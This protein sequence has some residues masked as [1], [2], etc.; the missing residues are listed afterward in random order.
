MAEGDWPEWVK[1]EEMVIQGNYMGGNSEFST[2]RKRVLKA[3]IDDLSQQVA[4]APIMW[5]FLIGFAAI[6][7]MFRSQILQVFNRLTQVPTWLAAFQ[8]RPS[9]QEKLRTLHEDLQAAL[10]AQH[11]VLMQSIAPGALASITKVTSAELPEE[12]RR[13]MEK[14]RLVD[15]IREEVDA[16]PSKEA[17]AAFEGG[18][19]VSPERPTKAL[20]EGIDAAVIIDDPAKMETGGLEALNLL[21]IGCIMC[22]GSEELFLQEVRHAHQ[23]LNFLLSFLKMQPQAAGKVAEVINQLMASPSWSAVLEAS[24]PLKETLRDLPDDAQIALGLQHRKVLELVGPEARKRAA[25]GD[26]PECV[27]GVADRMA[28]IRGAPREEVQPPLPPPPSKDEW[29][30]ARTPEGHTYYY[31]LRTRESTWDRPTALGGARVYKVGDEVEVWSNGQRVWGRGR[32]EKAE[33][34]NIVAEF[35]LPSGIAAKKELPANHKDLRPVRSGSMLKWSAEEQVTYQR[36]FDAIPGPASAKPGMLVA[37]FL[38]KSGLKR[39]CLKQLWHVANSGNKQD[40]GFEEFARCCRLVAH[41]QAMGSESPIVVEAE[42][43]LRVKLREECLVSR[44]G[45]LPSFGG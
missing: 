44:P 11:E 13:D 20:Q 39:P 24:L 43:P 27:R 3:S 22:A 7:K 33:G 4:H 19:D 40:L 14:E 31:N 41:C 25:G 35:T 23:V 8:S 30:E 15:E 36:W 9:L 29:K 26:V 34:G 32:V 16:S 38:S 12:V 2:F 18:A 6:K 21:R 5:D 10:G 45:T 42:R 17:A 37:Q 1:I 28:S